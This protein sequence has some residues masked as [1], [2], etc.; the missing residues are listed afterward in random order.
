M[1]ITFRSSSE[2]PLP[3]EEMRFRSVKVQPYPDGRRVQVSLE[4]TPFQV[5]PNIDISLLDSAGEVAASAHIV[6]ASEP[7]MSLTLHI[8]QGPASGRFTGQFTLGYS[9]QE[10]VDQASSGFEL[11]SGAN[12]SGVESVS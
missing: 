10:P 5:R 9:G 4:I 7:R 1:D 3:P 8:R 11:G 6:E 2:V 12:R